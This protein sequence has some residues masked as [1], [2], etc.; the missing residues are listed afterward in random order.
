MLKNRKI[1]R[2]VRHFAG[3]LIRRA[4]CPGRMKSMF[5][6]SKQMALSVQNSDDFYFRFNLTLHVAF[7]V[8][9]MSRTAHKRVKVCGILLSGYVIP[10]PKSSALWVII[11]TCSSFDL[12]SVQVEVRRAQIIKFESEHFYMKIANCG[13]NI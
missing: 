2:I 6:F 12:R 9:F 13:R 7:E 8:Y 10:L 3:A 5:I 1:P 4:K 11:A